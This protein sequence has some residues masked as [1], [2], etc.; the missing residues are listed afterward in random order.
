M[1][2]LTPSETTTITIRRLVP[3]SKL[4]YIHL[5]ELQSMC[6][7]CD[8]WEQGGNEL[9]HATSRNASRNG[10]LTYVR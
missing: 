1:S 5:M 9:E 6:Q 4:I 3:L 10:T 7:N 2:I 8:I